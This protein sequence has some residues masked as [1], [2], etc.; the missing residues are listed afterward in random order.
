MS[1][2][3]LVIERYEM[4]YR[5]PPGLEAPIRRVVEAYCTP[6]P[7]NQGG[8][9]HISSLYLDSR[10]RRL[11][12]ETIMRQPRR[13]KLR[14]RRYVGSPAFLEIKRRIKDVVH[15]SRVRIPNEAWPT[16][17]HD[18]TVA[19]GLGL[20]PAGQRDLLDFAARCLRI[21]AEPATVVRYER[22][23]W[24]GVA[25][26]YARVTF[27]HRLVAAEPR[28]WAVPVE[29]H[30]AAWY[31]V[32]EPRR[33]GLTQ[34]GVILELKCTK[35]V[36]YWMTDLVHRFRLRR[37]GFSK[38]ATCLEHVEAW[39]RPGGGMRRSAL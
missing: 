15:K 4:K 9:Y 36:P 35:E 27:D 30:E 24:E 5:I 16:A 37:C 19:A 38:Y 14:V 39:R 13:Y 11:Y 1:D 25:E 32:D 7:A 10:R 6:D 21:D 28:G 3:R 12:H 20:S 22:E 31:P 18:P 8:R 34:S 29:D 23:A 17:M 26:D 33:Y 2:G